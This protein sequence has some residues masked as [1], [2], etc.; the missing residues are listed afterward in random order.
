MD[1]WTKKQIVQSDLLDKTYSNITI[2][3]KANGFVVY[4]KDN[5]SKALFLDEYSFAR[6]FNNSLIKEIL[7]KEYKTILK[8][9]ASIKFLYP[10]NYFSIVPQSY[11]KEQE[12]S[13]YFLNSIS[14]IN[15]DLFDY[16]FTKVN[17]PDVICVNACSKGSIQDVKLNFPISEVI[18]ETQILINTCLENYKQNIKTRPNSLFLNFSGDNVDDVLF[19]DDKFLLMNR[20]EYRTIEN[21]IYFVL[22]TLS[23]TKQ[24]T[25]LVD[26]V[27]LGDI[28][29]QSSIV[30][31]LSKYFDRIHFIPSEIEMDNVVSHTY[32]LETKA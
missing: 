2:R 24:S 7:E 22:N 17:L 12:L 21:F 18:P 25:A 13:A 14:K 6:G 30:S 31:T 15:I 27:I 4:G 10:V 26:I 3:I 19:V 1:N 28:Q 8:N 9:D 29:K 20:F 11:F 23:Q 32:I 16:N 5:M